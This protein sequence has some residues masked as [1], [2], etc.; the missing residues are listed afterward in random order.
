MYKELF[1]N[2]DT[3]NCNPCLNKSFMCKLAFGMTSCYGLKYKKLFII[4][5]LWSIL[6]RDKIWLLNLYLV[7]LTIKISV[8]Y[9]VCLKIESPFTAT[10]H[11]LTNKWK[12]LFTRFLHLVEMLI[13]SLST[14]CCLYFICCH[15]IVN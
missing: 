15:E 3:N 1:K 11:I 5:V 13:H 6:E 2:K 8:Y 14:N 9:S 4:I 10:V 12:S 7:Y